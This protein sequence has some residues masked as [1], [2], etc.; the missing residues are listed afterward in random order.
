MRNVNKNRLIRK[1]SRE[2]LAK[3]DKHTR[4]IR[5]QYTSSLQ[6]PN[7][8]YRTYNHFQFTLSSN[9]LFFSDEQRAYFTKISL[10]Q[11]TRND[12]ILQ[13]IRRWSENTTATRVIDGSFKRFN[14]YEKEVKNREFKEKVWVKNEKTELGWIQFWLSEN[15]FHSNTLI[16]NQ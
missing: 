9:K 14:K 13:T 5:F 11:G 16:R 7:K 15:L 3:I 6:M 12:G 10:D 1:A 4:W 2:H 8:C